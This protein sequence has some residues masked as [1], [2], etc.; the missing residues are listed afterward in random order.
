MKELPVIGEKKQRTEVW[1]IDL[2]VSNVWL[3]SLN[4]P[5]IS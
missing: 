2:E 4:Q 5:K 1:A 3:L